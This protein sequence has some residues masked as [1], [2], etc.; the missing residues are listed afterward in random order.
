[1]PSEEAL[2]NFPYRSY[3]KDGEEESWGDKTQNGEEEEMGC[4]PEAQK[5]ITAELGPRGGF[6]ISSTHLEIQIPLGDVRGI[7]ETDAL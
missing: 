7:A 1:M 3:D 2:S 5:A 6:S 4:G